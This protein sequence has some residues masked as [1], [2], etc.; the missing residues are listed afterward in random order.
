MSTT[1]TTEPDSLDTNLLQSSF[2]K[3]EPQADEFAA[4]FYQILFDKYPRIQPLFLATDMEEQKIKLIKSLK[5]VIENVSK[6]EIL[7]ATLEDLGARHIQYGAVLN[8]YPLIG[9]ALL[10]ALEKHLD[11][12]WN[13]EVKQ[14]WTKAYG[15]IADI[16]TA[17]AKAAMAKDEMK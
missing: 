7:T 9:D 16:M 14:T 1:Q 15:A 6:A 3:I 11:K 5:I 13:A 8:D 12:D 2:L 4:T 17:G 10:Q